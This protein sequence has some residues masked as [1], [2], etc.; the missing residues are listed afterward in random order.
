MD[1]AG[2]GAG[3]GRGNEL[4][5]P[6]GGGAGLRVVYPTHN[7]KLADGVN[8]GERKKCE[9]GAAVNVVSAVDLPVI[10]LSAVCVDLERYHPPA[11]WRWSS[12]EKLVRVAGG[13]KAGQQNPRVCTGSA[14]YV[15]LSDLSAPTTPRV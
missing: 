2:N 9:I 7:A 12:R 11:D 6:A 13:R 4:D 1:A 15:K 14:C 3:A 10:F 8:A 5:L